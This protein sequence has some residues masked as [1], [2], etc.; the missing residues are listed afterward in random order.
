[1]N[2]F[3]R[4]FFGAILGL[5]VFQNTAHAACKMPVAPT[6]LSNF[7]KNPEG[8]LTSQ[9]TK[10]DALVWRV[11]IFASAGYASLKELEKLGT[12]ANL[13]QKNS[14]GEGLARAHSACSARDGEI[15]RRIEDAVRKMADRDITRA[16]LKILM[17]GES[18]PSIVSQKEDDSS[19]RNTLGFEDTIKLQRDMPLGSTKFK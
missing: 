18:N 7:L 9:G 5:V 14:F 2:S 3:F 15:A 13:A 6:T 10:N 1:M 4:V 11:R 8:I 16:Y 17:G 19:K 12:K